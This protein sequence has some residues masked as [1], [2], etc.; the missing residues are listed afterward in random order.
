MI[1][2]ISN[3]IAVIRSVGFTFCLLHDLV[4]QDELPSLEV[5]LPRQMTVKPLPV[6]GRA[7]VCLM[8]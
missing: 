1:S 2:W 7:Q 8:S 4:H 3:Y 5:Q 6:P